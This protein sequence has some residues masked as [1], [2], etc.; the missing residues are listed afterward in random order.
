MGN[1]VRKVQDYNKIVKDGL[2][3]VSAHNKVQSRVDSVYPKYSSITGVL[4]NRQWEGKRCFVFGGG[5]SLKGFDFSHFRNELTIG[6]NRVFEVFDT[7][8]HY[9]M[10][11]RFYHWLV[12]GTLDQFSGKPV[13]Q[14]WNNARGH[15]IFLCPFSFRPFPN[16]VYAIRRLETPSV[17]TDIGKGIYGSNNSGFGA[18]MLAVALG[19]NP[20]YLLGFDMKTDNN[21]NTHWH[22][23]YP[24]QILVNLRKKFLTYIES[25]EKFAPVFKQMRVNVINLNRDSGIRCFNFGDL[26]DI[27]PN[28]RKSE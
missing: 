3:Y 20:I 4:R 9:S 18:V 2:S 24:N 17:S 27:L 12:C 5:P 1:F 19:A 10:D 11:T 14:A 21:D 15:K 25:F 22:K 28:G 7:T 26:V 8:I 13:L 6:V 23:G 16:Y